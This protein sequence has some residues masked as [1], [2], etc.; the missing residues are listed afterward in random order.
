MANAVPSKPVSA[1]PTPL[2]ALN[3]PAL[4]WRRSNVRHTSNELYADVVESLTVT[5]APSGRPLAAFANGTIAFTSKVSGVPDMTLS[6]AGPSGKHNLGSFIELPVFHPCVRL[7]RWKERPGELSFVPPD[8]RFILAGYEVNLLPFTDGLPSGQLKLPIGLEMRT[9]LGSTGSEFDVRVQV[10]RMFGGSPSPRQGTRGGSSAGRGF[11]GPHVG[12][13][14][15][16]S[17]EDLSVRIPLPA[18][19]RNLPEIR[20]SRGDAVFNPTEQVLEWIIPSKDIAAG[21]SHFALRCT[22]VGLPTEQEDEGEGETAVPG[23]LTDYGYEEP[24]QATGTTPKKKGKGKGKARQ[25]GQVEGN[26]AEE[27]AKKAEQNKLLMPSSAQVGFSV[28]GWLASGLKVESIFLDPR[29]SRGL[30]E[31]VKPYK[32]VK[33]LTV[34]KGGVEIRC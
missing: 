28:K 32:G 20:P 5:L 3:A 23:S 21:T 2:A 19:V 25:P 14:A 18:D 16:P 9:G 27:N 22:A 1:A 29:R 12:T 10:N 8:G 26:G 13:P 33:Y 24:Y 15:A 7:A 30:G 11:G 17:L 31:G 34:S 6:L 4:P